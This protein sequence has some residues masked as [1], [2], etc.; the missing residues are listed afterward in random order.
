[1]RVINSR[2][3]SNPSPSSKTKTKFNRQKPSNKIDP[4][5]LHFYKLANRIPHTYEKSIYCRGKEYM[6]VINS[7][8][9]SNP[10]PSSKTKYKFNRQKPSSKIDP[11]AVHFY[12][13]ANRIPQTHE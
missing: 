5:D 1:M 8:L 11:L 3:V 4:L 7:H 13:L 6:H 2:L 10:W 12:E 9:V